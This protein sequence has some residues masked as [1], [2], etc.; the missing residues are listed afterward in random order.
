MTTVT[1]SPAFSSVDE[2][3]DWSE[4]HGRTPVVERGP[5]GLYRGSVEHRGHEES[6]ALDRNVGSR[7]GT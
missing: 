1:R 5:D 7:G 4:R 3:L 2:L 6:E